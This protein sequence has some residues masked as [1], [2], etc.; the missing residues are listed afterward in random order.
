MKILISGGSRGIGAACVR[1]FSQAGWDVCFLYHSSHEAAQALSRETGARALCVDA[2]DPAAVAECLSGERFDALL[3]CAGIASYGLFQDLSDAEWDRLFA[4]NVGSVR[5]CVNAVLPGMLHAGSGSIVTLGSIWGEVGASC[6]AAYS[7]TKGA[8]MALTMALA[9]ELGPSGIRVNCL[10]P[11]VIATDMIGHLGQ[12]DL[13][14]LREETPLGR[15]GTP[16]EVA[17][18]ALFLC[19]TESRFIT[20]Q[21]LSVGGGFG[22]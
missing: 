16:E 15:I 2:S 21:V 22:K 7:A 13:A 3:C 10:S 17:D 6:E 18:A 12:E 5:S 1:R 4:V 9:K 19:S 20:G 11:G 8:V 14:A